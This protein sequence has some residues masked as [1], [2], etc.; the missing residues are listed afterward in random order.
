[1]VQLSPSPVLDVLAPSECSRPGLASHKAGSPKMG[2]TGR[3]KT[4]QMDL[5]AS[6]T[7]YQGY[8]RYIEDG[9]ICLKHKIRNIEKKKVGWRGGVGWIDGWM[10]VKV[11]VDGSRNNCF[12][13]L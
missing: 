8:D 12:L 6:N 2:S 13:F 11:E 7:I 4:L 3:L 1:M 10:D 9:L 5:E